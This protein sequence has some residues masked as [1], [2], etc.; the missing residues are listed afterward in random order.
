MEEIISR[1]ETLLSGSVRERVLQ[2]L[3]E[4]DTVAALEWGGAIAS[5]GREEEENVSWAL[6]VAMI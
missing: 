2:V 1:L 6:S 4:D 3:L 5:K